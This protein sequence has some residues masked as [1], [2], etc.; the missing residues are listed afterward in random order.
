MESLSH[1]VMDFEWGFNGSFDVCFLKNM[2][3]H[4]EQILT[5]SM[6]RVLSDLFTGFGNFVKLW[7]F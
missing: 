4:V 5:N 2:A 6:L 3:F 7:G 1:G